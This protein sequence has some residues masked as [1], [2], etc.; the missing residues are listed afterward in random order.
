MRLLGLF[1]KEIEDLL[2]GGEF[3]FACCV[4]DGEDNTG[5]GAIGNDVGEVA[6][7]RARGFLLIVALSL[8]DWAFWE[9]PNTTHFLESAST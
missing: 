2:K 8:T 9:L 6:T 7:G 4:L 1:F 5:G 3:E